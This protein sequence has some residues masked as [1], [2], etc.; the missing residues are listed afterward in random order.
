MWEAKVLLH[1]RKQNKKSSSS[2]V[3]EGLLCKGI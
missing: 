2:A 1:S 3:R